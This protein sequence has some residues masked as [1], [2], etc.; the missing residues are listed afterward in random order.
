MNGIL[1]RW[2]S[3]LVLPA[4]I[5]VCPACEGGGGDGSPTGG[6]GAGLATS[7][8]GP[9]GTGGDGATGGTG[10]DDGSDGSD[11][12]DGTGVASGTGGAG[13]GGAGGSGASL[14]QRLQAALDG[15]VALQEVPGGTAAVRFPDGAVWTGATGLR[16]IDPPEP[17]APGSVL[18]IGSVTKTFVSTVL[19]QLWTEGAIDLDAPLS[20]WLDLVP[21]GDVVTL[22]QILN[23]TSGI[24][25]YFES[26]AFLEALFAEPQRPWAP[27]ELVAYG[28]A[29]EP[30]FAPGTG[31]RYSNTNYILAGL[32][33]EAAT[34]RPAVEELRRRV[35]DPLE[36]GSTFLDASEPVPVELARGYFSSEEITLLDTTTRYHESQGWTAGS[37]VSSASDVARF[38]AA[39]LDVGGG[40]L[41]EAPALAEMKTFLPLGHP[42]YTGYGLGLFARESAIGPT[43]GHGGATT[44]YLASAY[45]APAKG[46]TVT[47]LLSLTGGSAD[48]DVVADALFEVLG[49]AAF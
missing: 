19:L 26:A 2:V 27:E 11:G 47:V 44:G 15:T 16:R 20:T 3:A 40:G 25:D 49:D 8:G 1:R 38:M 21:D 36:L 35:L 23:H 22:R 34:G 12:S 41:L 9:A 46:V 28:V 29:Q 48:A 6:G 17:M 10:G 24:P 39:L 31:W 18:R 37:L 13:E 33:L 32:V 4:L 30:Y 7:S 43:Y 42:T 14:E 5:Y 45:Y